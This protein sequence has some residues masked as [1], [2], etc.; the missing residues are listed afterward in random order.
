MKEDIY[1]VAHRQSTRR[2]WR[3]P[4]ALLPGKAK[5]RMCRRRLGAVATVR[6]AGADGIDSPAKAHSNYPALQ[7]VQRCP[8]RRRMP[9]LQTQP[10]LGVA[11][12]AMLTMSHR[13]RKRAL[14]LSTVVP[15]E[16]DI[17]A[18]ELTS[19]WVKTYVPQL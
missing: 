4:F 6:E 1:S 13:G 8:S 12:S 3:H 18:N 16:A 15:R 14:W 19:A 2:K 10:R 7:T 5:F 17:A 9:I 11:A